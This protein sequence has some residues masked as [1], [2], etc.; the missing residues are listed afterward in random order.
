MLLFFIGMPGSGKT[1]WSKKMATILSCPVLDLDYEIERT[2]N[3]SIATLFSESEAD[4]RK[5]EHEILVD[6]ISKNHQKEEPYII[7]AGGGTP[8]Y[9]ENL[10]LMTAY[11][12]TVYLKETTEHLLTR[13]IPETKSRPLFQGTK[14]E[15]FHQL[16]SLE[17]ERSQFYEQANF[18]IDMHNMT[19]PE[20]SQ[21]IKQIINCKNPITYV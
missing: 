1:F 20:F 3:T 13:I 21:K 16:Q 10:K 18:I 17:K 14:E 12:K 19:L 7:A 2:T 5:I 11:G 9:H 4:F 8:C 6:L 15:I